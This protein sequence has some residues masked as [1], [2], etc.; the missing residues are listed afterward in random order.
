MSEALAD[1][2]GVELA[3]DHEAQAP[4][5]GDGDVRSAAHLPQAGDELVAPLPH[6]FQH[7]LLLKHIK[8]RHGGRDGH[9]IAP[10]GAAHATDLLSRGELRPR[11]HHGQRVPRGDTLGGYQDV[12]HDAEMLHSP[13]LACP[14]E[15]T[16]HLVSNEQDVVLRAPFPQAV[17]ESRRRHDVA[18]LAEHWLNDDSGDFRGL[19]LLKEKEVQRCQGLFGRH[20]GVLVWVPREHSAC[21]QRPRTLA[22]VAG[23]GAG[24]CERA[25]GAAVVATEESDHGVALLR[26]PRELQGALYR[27]GSGVGKEE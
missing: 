19:R 1:D 13:L 22:T 23:G 18:A 14:A 24:D 7:L 16:L 6:V 11:R 27:L 9:C 2:R 5:I 17:H 20:A 3:A 21:G 8:R 12:G 26:M 15:A 10:I 4:D 25:G